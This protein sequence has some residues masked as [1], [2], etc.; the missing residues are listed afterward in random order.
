MRQAG[1]CQMQMRAVAMID[2]REDS[3]LAERMFQIDA[4]RRCMPLRLRFESGAALH[5]RSRKLIRTRDSVD[6]PCIATVLGSSD[7][8]DAIIGA[9]LYEPDAHRSLLVRP[10]R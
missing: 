1:A 8:A 4:L 10:S 9:Q 2:R 6:P 5:G 3:L 7:D